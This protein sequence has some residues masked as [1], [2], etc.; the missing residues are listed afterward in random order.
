MGLALL[1]TIFTA[2][3]VAQD[4]EEAESKAYLVGERPEPSGPPTPVTVGIYLLDI[5]EINDVDQRFR[6]D[7]FVTVRWQD[8][9]L[10][11]PEEDRK[12]LVRRFSVDEIWQP[13]GFV[14][15]DR[16]LTSGLPRMADVDDL[17][18]VL[19]NSICL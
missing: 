10:A 9:R 11:L 6:V 12:G 7:M 3:A 19:V 16:G 15:N 8:A 18:N 17:G 2:L 14:I 5:D 1:L 13:R 4:S